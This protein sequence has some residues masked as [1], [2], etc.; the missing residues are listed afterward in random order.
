MA[1]AGLT[2]P[3]AGG[4]NGLS[5]YSESG[6]ARIRTKGENRMTGTKRSRPRTDLVA[7]L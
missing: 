4:C 5:A 7:A 2:R 1:G 6:E 3:I